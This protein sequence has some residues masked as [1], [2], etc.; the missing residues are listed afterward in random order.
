[1]KQETSGY[2]RWHQQAISTTSQ[3]SSSIERCQIGTAMFDADPLVTDGP[4]PPLRLP[5]V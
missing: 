3:Q 5:S 4:V 1:L 2:Q